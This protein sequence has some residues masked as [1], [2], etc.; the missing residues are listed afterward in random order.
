VPPGSVLLE[1]SGFEAPDSK[2]FKQPDG[3]QK[4]D[5]DLANEIGAETDTIS[6]TKI[7][8]EADHTVFANW[9]QVD[10]GQTVTIKLKYRLPF[11]IFKE[12]QQAG[13]ILQKLNIANYDNATLGAYSLLIQKQPGSSGSSLHSILLYDNNQMK[14][15]WKYPDTLEI[16]KDGWT[17]NDIL[18]RDKFFG[19]V[20]GN[21]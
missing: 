11:K 16:K 3:G 20:L 1:A 4:T 13:N 10:P 2:L 18:N 19:M 12:N 15:V 8:D 17:V 5:P 6:G 9:S 7:Y 21:Y 14:S